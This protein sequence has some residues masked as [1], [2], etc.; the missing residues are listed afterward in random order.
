MNVLLSVKP[1]YAEK[2]VEGEKKYEFRRAIFK[3][4]DIEK[5]Y[6]DIQA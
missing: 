1:K 6:H 5:V 3:K 2:I 4:Q